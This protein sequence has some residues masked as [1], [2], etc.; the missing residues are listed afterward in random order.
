LGSSS[1]VIVDTKG[2]GNM[3]Y[4]P[5]DKLM[6]QRG[7]PRSGTVT[8]EPSVSSPPDGSSDGSGKSDLRNRGAR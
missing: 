5:L 3:I 1:K 6:E 4:L 8:V 7:Q 2:T